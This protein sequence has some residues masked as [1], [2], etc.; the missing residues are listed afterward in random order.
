[1]SNI[2]NGSEEIIQNPA[3]KDKD[4]K[5]VRGIISIPS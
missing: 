1:M 3:Q 2:E 5:N 4:V